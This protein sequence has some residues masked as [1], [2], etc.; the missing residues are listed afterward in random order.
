MHVKPLRDMVL[1]ERGHLDERTEGGIYIPE[2]ASP[3]EQKGRVV[4]AGPGR[5]LDNGTL[6]PMTVKEGD[7]VYFWLNR[8]PTEVKVKGETYLLLNEA[9]ILA[10]LETPATS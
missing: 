4:A 7:V 5:T 6:K 3:T 1:V 8:P 9:E 10:V 2:T